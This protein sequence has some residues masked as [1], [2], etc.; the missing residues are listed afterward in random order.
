MTT[1]SPRPAATD[2]LVLGT[3]ICQR[4]ILPSVIP[5]ILQRLELQR[6]HSLPLLRLLIR[7]HWQ[8]AVKL[9][10]PFHNIF[11]QSSRIILFV[12]FHY[13]I[14]KKSRILRLEP[15]LNRFHRLLFEL[16]TASGR[17]WGKRLLVI[18]V[19]IGPGE[20]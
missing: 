16:K 14:R 15:L 7:P 20:G 1:I 12:K 4:H 5:L 10:S 11:P 6:V 2:T 3:S 13:V 8:Y 18:L 17:F 9:R 19:W